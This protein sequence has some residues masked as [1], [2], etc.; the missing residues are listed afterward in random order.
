MYTMT[1]EQYEILM[2]ALSAARCGLDSLV[3][4]T[5]QPLLQSVY[6][7]WQDEIRQASD[8]VFEYQRDVESL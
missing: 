7:S 1:L 3:L 8:I 5:K 2:R 4:A 6:K